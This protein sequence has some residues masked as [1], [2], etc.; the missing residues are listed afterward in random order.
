ML[1]EM[2]FDGGEIAEAVTL[3]IMALIFVSLAISI[4]VI[5]ISDRRNERAIPSPAY[6]LWTSV[7]M[8]ILA[9]LCIVMMLSLANTRGTA[10]AITRDLEAQGFC[11]EKVS[12]KTATVCSP[13]GY[14]YEISIEELD[15]QW[16]ALWGSQKQVAGPSTTTIPSAT[17]RT[18]RPEDL[19]S[20]SKSR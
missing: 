8:I 20:T 4:V 9:G 2:V 7:V 3:G 1:A 11:V 6:V 5:L 10:V 19:A 18:L 17:P 13:D 15:G 16:V 12:D 14:R